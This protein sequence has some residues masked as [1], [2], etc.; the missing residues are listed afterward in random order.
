VFVTLAPQVEKLVV[1]NEG[2]YTF[3]EEFQ[4]LTEDVVY[5]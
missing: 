3:P 1:F 2:T 4:T 5:E